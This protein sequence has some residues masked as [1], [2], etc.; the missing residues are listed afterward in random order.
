[1]LSNVNQNISGILSNT[2]K[3]T[4]SVGM[5]AHVKGHRDVDFRAFLLLATII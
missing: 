2:E 1:M 4:T 5:S 3:H